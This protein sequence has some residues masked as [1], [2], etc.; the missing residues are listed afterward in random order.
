MDS[1]SVDECGD[2]SKQNKLNKTYAGYEYLPKD[3]TV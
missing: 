3:Y 2:L 1:S